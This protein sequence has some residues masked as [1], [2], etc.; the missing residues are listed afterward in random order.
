MEYLLL[1]ILWESRYLLLNKLFQSLFCPLTQSV[2]LGFPTC[3]IL[4]CEWRILSTSNLISASAW[5]QL[6]VLKIVLHRPIGQDFEGRA[7][8]G[9]GGARGR[10]FSTRSKRGGGA[11]QEQEGPSEYIWITITNM[12]NVQ[13]MCRFDLVSIVKWNFLEI[14][15]EA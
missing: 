1:V 13:D 9:G 7:R 5:C 6:L 12:E 15:S 3:K 2:N 8:E 4:G 11:R 14:M 10:R